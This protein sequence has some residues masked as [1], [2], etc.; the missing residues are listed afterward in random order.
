[1]IKLLKNPHLQAFMLWVFFSMLHW[2]GKTE[3]LIINIIILGIVMLILHLFIWGT[4]EV[5]DGIDCTEYD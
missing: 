4:G 3:Q 5:L 2:L 1:M